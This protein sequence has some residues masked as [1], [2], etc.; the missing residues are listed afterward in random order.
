MFD[1]E[2]GLRSSHETEEEECQRLRE[3][4]PI[5]VIF[6]TISIEVEEVQLSSTYYLLGKTLFKTLSLCVLIWYNAVDQ[7]L[8][9]AF[10]RS[11]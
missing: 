8:D 11:L 9:C 1:F 7:F 10:Y 2:T 4:F 6:L 5:I 3:L